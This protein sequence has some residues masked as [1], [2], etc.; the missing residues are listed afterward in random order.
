MDRKILVLTALT[1]TACATKPPVAPAHENPSL[2][3]TEAPSEPAP[4]QPAPETSDVLPPS[5]GPTQDLPQD[6]PVAPAEV[7]AP[8]Q[9][10]V[11]I[12]GAGLEAMAALG[13]LQE[14]ERAGHKPVKI[15]GTGFGCWIAVSWALE[16]SGNR[17]EW[18]SFK[19]NSWD[20][21]PRGGL[22]G[23]LR[24]QSARRGFEDDVGR[25]LT[26]K[27]FGDLAAPADCPLVMAKRPE[28]LTTGRGVSIATNLWFQLQSPALGVEK[29]EDEAF[30]GLAAGSPVPSE[31][32]AFSREF[33]KEGSDFGGWIVL[34]TRTSAER[35]GF[36]E[37]S[38][39][40]AA[41]SDSTLGVE[42]AFGSGGK[43]RWRVIDLGAGS[44]RQVSDVGRFERRRE[45]LLQ[46]RQAGSAF[47]A[48]RPD[49]PTLWD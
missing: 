16:N 6:A 46:G 18:Q 24:R 49:A 22:L 40:L 2:I 42:G 34:R 41:R 9:F 15:V 31:L 48:R 25:F 11:W 12:D 17:A 43:Y 47:L 29:S 23:K 33:Q 5:A 35:S 28:Q 4:G 36:S 14:L 45:W 44:R 32:D 37:W 1:L 8:K 10:A 39:V 7:V 26:A 21:L 13:F 38:T 19:W 20:R 3:R 30:S 27:S